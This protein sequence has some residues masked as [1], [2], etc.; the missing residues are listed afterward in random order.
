MCERLYVKQNN[1]ISDTDRGGTSSRVQ[2]L[3]VVVCMYVCSLFRKLYIYIHILLFHSPGTNGG[4]TPVGLVA[5]FLGGLTVGAAYF[6]TQ[7][8]LVSD[9]HLADP[10]WPIVV[11]GG[12]AGLL[13]SM[14]DSFLGAH[15]QYS[16]TQS[17]VTDV[18][19][20]TGTITL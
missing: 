14:L 4:V 9:L 17:S 18:S 10:Q 16:G 3:C 19:P 8:L 20:H 5:S 1:R 6:V 7:L 13:G 11:Y 15:M 2:F 12:V